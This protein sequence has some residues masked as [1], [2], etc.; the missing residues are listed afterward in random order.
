MLD[1]VTT[2]CDPVPDNWT[3]RASGDVINLE[4]L[5]CGEGAREIVK[6]AGHIVTTCT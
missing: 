1:G 4:R 2:D 3:G 5:I 6:S